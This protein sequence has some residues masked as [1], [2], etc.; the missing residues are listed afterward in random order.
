MKNIPEKC[1]A[2]PWQEES[3]Q[4]AL[5]KP[6]VRVPSADAEVLLRGVRIRPA[7]RSM[8]RAPRRERAAR[9]RGRGAPQAEE[10]VPRLLHSLWMLE[11]DLNAL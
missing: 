1:S 6:S 11:V 10:V 2:A 3:P 9:R 7:A 4:D 5:T 8:P